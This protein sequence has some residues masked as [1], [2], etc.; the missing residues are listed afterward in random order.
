MGKCD[1]VERCF[2]CEKA[3]T[4]IFCDYGE[5]VI[6][7]GCDYGAI[8]LY[9]P[10]VDSEFIQKL[11]VTGSEL[12]ELDN[13]NFE[14]LPNLRSL[15][16]SNNLIEFLDLK[17]FENVRSLVHVDLS[18]NR[19]TAAVSI[20]V[21]IVLTVKSLFLS[22]N[23]CIDL[24]YE[25][26]MEDI[27]NLLV[28]LESCRF[29]DIHCSYKHNDTCKMT[30]NVLQ[31]SY[32]LRTITVDQKNYSS[33]KF[34]KMEVIDRIFHRI[35]INL[36]SFIPEL[37]SLI[38]MRSRLRYIMHDDLNNLHN[39]KRLIL[40]HNE[41]KVIEKNAFRSLKNLV[42]LDLSYNLRARLESQ[43]ITKFKKL[44]EL[45]LL[46]TSCVN[47]SSKKDQIVKLLQRF[48]D[49]CGFYKKNFEWSIN[50]SPRIYAVQ[51]FKDSN[52]EKKMLKTIVQTS[53]KYDMLE[54]FFQFLANKY[55]KCEKPYFCE[56]LDFKPTLT[57]CKKPRLCK[58]FKTKP[59]MN[60]KTS[61]IVPKM[62]VSS[63]ISLMTEIDFKDMMEWHPHSEYEIE[64]E[65]FR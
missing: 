42:T 39:L 30:N 38:I 2:V 11:I 13:N 37:E 3:L 57:K 54:V 27:Q 19:L 33:R 5:K 65:Q 31:D 51:S 1:Y 47:S 49:G 60:E 46:S 44:K 43:N 28:A 32:E 16:L 26:D 24:N 8:S 12:S 61:E 17:V 20:D 62:K 23:M 64:L 48:R 4:N 53:S 25:D 41:L 10:I 45:N 50:S 56:I 7:G 22:K 40:S 15:D 58:L 9:L 36:G 14:K 35:P 55:G 63:W 59:S 6:M 18:N 29:V 34:R 52:E 21:I